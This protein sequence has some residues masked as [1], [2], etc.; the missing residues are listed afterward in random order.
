MSLTVLASE[1]TLQTNSENANKL[2]TTSVWVQIHSLR[3]P[4]RILTE[5]IKLALAA[6]TSQATVT[7]YTVEQ[8][9]ECERHGSIP[10]RAEALHLHYVQTGSGSA[11]PPLR[12]ISGALY[13][14][15]S[16]YTQHGCEM[17]PLS[18]N[19]GTNFAGTNFAD[20]RRSLGR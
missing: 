1:E 9:K 8:L 15:E 14:H 16:I 11:Q 18:A 5:L 6:E 4:R 10:D 20:K 19:V 13:S 12:Y 17:T 3:N 7:S 2:C